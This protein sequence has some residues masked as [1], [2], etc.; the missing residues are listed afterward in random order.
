MKFIIE[1]SNGNTYRDTLD[2]CVLVSPV[3]FD[4]SESA[5]PRLEQ[6]G[7]VDNSNP[8]IASRKLTLWISKSFTNDSDYFYFKSKT[9]AFFLNNKPP[10][11]LVDVANRR[12]TKV[13]FSKFSEQF[14]KGSEARIEKEV[15]LEFI[16]ND[17]LWEDDEESD[18][19]FLLLASGGSHGLELPDNYLDGY[20]IFEL[21][22]A[23]DYNPDFAFDLYDENGKGFATIRIQSLTFSNSTEANKW[24]KI[25]NDYGRIYIGGRP[26]PNTV[27]TYSKNNLLWTGGNFLRFRSGMNRIVYVSIN[28][29]PILFRLRS[30]GRRSN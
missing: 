24:M 16:L 6:W 21:E 30:R 25:D 20:G 23:S 3:D 1:D 12:R 15:P 19:D 14:D 29:S 9:T 2:P 4:L 28:S 8:Y 18:S 26:N 17:V 27:I 13:K 10:F 7:S 11:Y 5:I 22:A